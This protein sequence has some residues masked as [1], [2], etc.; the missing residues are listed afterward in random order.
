VLF[1]AALAIQRALTEI[2][3]KNAGRAEPELSARIG[4]ES[5]PVVLETAGEVFGDAPN[6]AARVQAAAD[7]GSVLITMN[8]QRQ[9]AGLFVAEDHGTRQLKGGSEP[10]PLFRI[11]R[12][13]GAGRRGGVRTLTPLI[14]HEEEVGLLLRRWE[15]VRKGE[16]QLVMI[17]GARAAAKPGRGPGG[18]RVDRL[19]EV[20]DARP[21]R[22]R[23]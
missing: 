10:V 21:F 23:L 5:G 7:P 12:P 22:G 4:I 15:C 19:R 1:D 8:V 18:L 16:G 9:V 11:V 14:G 6:V 2:N 17:L 3:A 20:C 13:S